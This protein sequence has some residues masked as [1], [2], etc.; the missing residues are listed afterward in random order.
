MGCRPAL[1]L[2]VDALA[3]EATSVTETS[4]VAFRNAIAR[5]LSA[6]DESAELL[7]RLRPVRIDVVDAARPGRPQ[8]PPSRS[9]SNFSPASRGPWAITRTRPSA[10][11]AAYPVRPSSSARQRVHQRKPTSW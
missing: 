2:P 9:R 10:R 4:D 7:R 3:T 5:V 11:F 6:L 8:A 1:N